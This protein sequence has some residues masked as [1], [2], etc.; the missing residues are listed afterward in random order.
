MAWDNHD[1]VYYLTKDGWTTDSEV[2]NTAVW[3]ATLNIYQRSGW[4]REVLTWSGGPV[5]DWIQAEELLVRFPAPDRDRHDAETLKR[6]LTQ[7]N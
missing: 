1:I 4:S 3:R 6:L 2:A 7:S 5:T